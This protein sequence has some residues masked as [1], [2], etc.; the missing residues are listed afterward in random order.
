MRNARSAILASAAAVAL[1]TGLHASPVLAQAAPSEASPNIADEG[2][3]ND[4]LVVTGSRIRRDPTDQPSPVVVLDDAAIARTGLSSIADTLQR[5][6][7]AAGGLNTKNNNSGNQGNPPDGGGV[8]AGSAQI[9]LRYLGAKRTLVLVDGLRYVN[10][11]S[12]SG[13]PGTVDLNSIPDAMIGRVEVLQSGAS[14]LYGSDAIAGVVNIITRSNQ[15]GFKAQAQYGQFLKYNDGGTQNYQ[16]SWGNGSA[17]PVDLTAGAFYGE[18]EPGQR[19]PHD[20]AIPQ[21]RPDELRRRDRRLLQLH[22]ARP[23]PRQWAE[24]DA[25]C[26][27]QRSSDLRPDARDRRL[28]GVHGRGP[29]QLRAVQLLPDAQR[30]LR[31]LHQRAGSILRR[32]EPAREDGLQPSRQ[33]EQGGVPAAADRAGRRA[34]GRPRARSRST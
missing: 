28:Q 16:L 10:G 20:L 17:A 31:R 25:A 14:P 1:A 29:L 27:G 12:A 3:A 24:P 26:A 32:A 33:H 23:L 19:G 22:A 30:A 5:I 21:S 7:S 34:A 13:I 6:P 9:D 11:A 2:P 8:G 4:D 15:D 18:A